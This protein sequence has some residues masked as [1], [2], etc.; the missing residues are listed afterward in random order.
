VRT[1]AL[2]KKNPIQIFV[3]AKL[4]FFIDIKGQV[5]AFIHLVIIQAKFVSRAFL[6]M[7]IPAI[8]KEDTASIQE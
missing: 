1:T 3:Q 6:N 7:V 4:A 5:M 2:D 8:G